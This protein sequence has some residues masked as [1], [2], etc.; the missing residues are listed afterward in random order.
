VAKVQRTLSGGLGA[1]AAKEEWN[2]SFMNMGH[3]ERASLGAIS[4]GNE[5][6]TMAKKNLM[7]MYL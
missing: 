3:S 2:L 7:N 1:V 5:K 6:R 4:A